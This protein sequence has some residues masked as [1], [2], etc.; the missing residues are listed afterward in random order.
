MNFKNTNCTC[1]L[2]KDGSVD[3][4][5]V[6]GNS[7]KDQTIEESCKIHYDHS[8]NPSVK[9]RDLNHIE[10]YD[11]IF[12]YVMLQLWPFAYTWLLS[13]PYENEV[14]LREQNVSLK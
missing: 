3:E 10:C 11:P 14:T 1:P 8:L 9:C 4:E 5:S 2:T 7:I 13:K 6:T 12:R